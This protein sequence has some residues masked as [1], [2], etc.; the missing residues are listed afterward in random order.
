MLTVVDWNIYHYSQF[1]KPL[2]PRTGI[3]STKYFPPYHA[4]ERSLGVL[5]MHDRLP[6]QLRLHIV[7]DLVQIGAIFGAA[8]V[9]LYI[10]RRQSGFLFLSYI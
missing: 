5:L 6:R 1:K 7:P 10:T 3:S 9:H 8:E 2:E 4:R